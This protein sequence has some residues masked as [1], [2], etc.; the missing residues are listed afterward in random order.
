MITIA[1]SKHNA[2]GVR[3]FVCDFASDKNNLPVSENPG[4]TALII[5][6]GEKYILNSYHEWILS[7]P[8]CC[9]NSN[10][11]SGSG[12]GSTTPPVD[13]D[14]DLEVIYDGGMVL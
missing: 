9:S 4:S 11:G 2:Y 12:S 8:S 6:T 5:E 1:N 13:E 10:T 3:N 14:L 7:K